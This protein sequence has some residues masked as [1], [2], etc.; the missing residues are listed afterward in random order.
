MFGMKSQLFYPFM[1]F[2]T[3]LSFSCDSLPSFISSKTSSTIAVCDLSLCAFEE[4][5]FE[6]AFPT[7]QV[8]LIDHLV[9][10]FMRATCAY[11]ERHP[12]LLGGL[13]CFKPK[14]L[15]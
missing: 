12:L 4:D 15:T 10:I 2:G 6:L 9:F 13:H 14:Q 1:W 3:S 7:T 8:V 11:I 5:V